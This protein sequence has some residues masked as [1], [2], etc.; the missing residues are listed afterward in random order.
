MPKWKKNETEFRVA[1]TENKSCGTSYSYI[2]KPILKELGN[3]VKLLFKKSK[4][5]IV[6]KSGDD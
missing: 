6:V 5:Q 3:P 4:G 2:P 1:I